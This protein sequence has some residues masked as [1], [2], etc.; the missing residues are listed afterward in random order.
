MKL[1]SFL[2]KK[3]SPLIPLQRGKFDLFSAS[4]Q[5]IKGRAQA[6]TLLFLFF[7]TSSISAQM[8]TDQGILYGNE[9]IN[10]NQSYYKIT[11]VEE[12]VYRLTQN[13]L[14][15]AGVFN[16]STIPKGQDFQLFYQGKEVPIYVTNVGTWGNNDYLE[17][18]AQINKGEID[19]YLYEEKNQQL[20]LDYNLFTDTASYFLTW[21]TSVE[22]KRIIAIDNDLNNLPDSETHCLVSLKENYHN[23]YSRGKKYVSSDGWAS[24]FDLV[25][26]W[27]KN[28]FA[29]NQNITLKLQNLYSDNS[30]SKLNVRFFS[31]KGDH[32]ITIKA[33][34][35]VIKNDSYQNWAVKSYDIEISTNQLQ[36]GN[37]TI[38]IEGSANEDDK[39]R[40][41]SYHLQYPHNFDFENKEIFQFDLPQDG[42]RRYL[43][44]SNFKHGGLAPILYDLNNQI[45]IPTKLEGN[46]VKVVLPA[47]SKLAHLILVSQTN[48]NSTINLQKRNFTQYDFANGD[49]D[50]LILSHKDLFKPIN[51]VNQVQAYADY[52]AS[53]AGGNF[54]PLVIDVTQVY[55]QFGYGIRWHQM[56]IKNFMALA[57][58]H[59]NSS[60]LYILGKGVDHVLLRR[61][62]ENWRQFDFVP[63]FGQPHSDYLFVSKKSKDV[64][65]MAVG[66]IAAK[67]PEDVQLYLNK[68]KEFEATASLP[69]TIEDKAWM[70]RVLHFGGGDANIQ[71][72]IASGLNNLKDILENSQQG[73][74]VKS[75]FKNSTDVIQSSQVEEVKKNINQGTGLLTFFGHSAPNTLDF[76]VGSPEEYENKGKYP[77]FF[78]VGCNTNRMFEKDH[79]LSE[80][81]VL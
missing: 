16:S 51:G 68:V 24:R 80:D 59:W 79:T 65:R 39:F 38:Q 60:Y 57:S 69:Q 30:T 71:D 54:K 20:N 26:G 41:V 66:R 73:G 61:S 75:F 49:Y 34:G 4:L 36:A 76:D 12:G 10:Y 70:K 13:D 23:Y 62:F 9:W 63:S 50:Y 31:E 58:Q 53:A 64:P 14:A 28:T 25:E 17:F 6:I 46:I 33:N 11:I 2:N 1:Y 77:L 22:K 18:Y 44:I 27:S 37:N 74:D 42:N 48:I 78:A 8:E 29:T 56:A 72:F 7:F 45:R 3:I 15:T 19:Q 21:N 47:I 67:S 35:A 52:R 43:E 40:L 55:D 5:G 32:E 81:F